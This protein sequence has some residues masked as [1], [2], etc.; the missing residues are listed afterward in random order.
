MYAG[1][2][3]TQGV[4]STDAIKSWLLYAMCCIRCLGALTAGEA[5]VC[6]SQESSQRCGDVLW[7][8]PVERETTPQP[9][10]CGRWTSET[11]LPAWPGADEAC[12][13]VASA[14]SARQG[15]HISQPQS[16]RAR[17]GR[18]L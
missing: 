3:E 6:D 16:T 1:V 17:R 5:G 4:A 7:T 15:L 13:E 10:W 9:T 14:Q 2:R 8:A 12:H 18:L 11:L